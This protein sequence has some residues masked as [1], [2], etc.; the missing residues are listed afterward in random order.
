MGSDCCLTH[1]LDI[2]P[3]ALSLTQDQSAPRVVCGAG[4]SR[5][6]FTA[7]MLLITACPF[8]QFTSSGL[9]DFSHQ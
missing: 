1:E 3:G 4:P 2:V 8:A 6:R 9:S 7:L 5:P